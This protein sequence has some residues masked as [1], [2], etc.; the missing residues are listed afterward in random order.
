[1]LRELRDWL[2]EMACRAGLDGIPSPARAVK[3][4]LVAGALV[5]VAWAVWGTAGGSAVTAPAGS[6]PGSGPIGASAATSSRAA[7]GPALPSAPS[8]ITVHVVG[9]VRHPGVYALPG[10]ARAIDAVNAAGGLLGDAEQSAVNLARVVA[11]GEQIAVPRQGEAAGGVGGAGAAA[12]APGSPGGG[13]VD[14]NTATAEQLDALPGVGPATATKIIADRSAN[15]PFRNVDDLMRV[16][17]IGPSKFDAL[18]D[19]IRT[20]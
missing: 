6:G 9:E 16:P 5:L 2:E 7:T 8:S 10:G 12:G 14:I 18:K 15:G 17:G 19:L 3:P 13:K 20:S 4:I 1:M 11:D